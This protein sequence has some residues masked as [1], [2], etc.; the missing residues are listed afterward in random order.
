MIPV[1]ITRSLL[2]EFG[3]GGLIEQFEKRLGKVITDLLVFAIALLIFSWCVENMVSI[4]VSSIRFWELGGQVAIWGLLKIIFFHLVL[5]ITIATVC[6]RV[7]QWMKN[8][9]IET[10]RD[11]AAKEKNEIAELGKNKVN[12]I[13]ALRKKLKDDS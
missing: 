6:Y 4:Y 1:A 9:T 5:I 11:Y 13:L 2:V 8:R 3:F 7:L 12:E 10:I